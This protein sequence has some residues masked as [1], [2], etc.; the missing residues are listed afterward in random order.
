MTSAMMCS[1][2]GSIESRFDAIQLHLHAGRKC[3]TLI[4]A[5]CYQLIM[6]RPTKPVVSIVFD[7]PLLARID[8]IADRMRRTRSSIVVSLCLDALERQPTDTIKVGI[9]H[10]QRD[11]VR[12]I[13]SPDHQSRRRRRGARS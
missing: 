3:N 2:F 10:E 13:A 4:A 7:D 6:T 1:K 5:N 11:D 12:G 9:I 8:R